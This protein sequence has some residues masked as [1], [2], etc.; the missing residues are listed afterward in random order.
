MKDDKDFAALGAVAD[1]ESIPPVDWPESAGEILA[2]L[3]RLSVRFISAGNEQ[4]SPEAR[5][6]LAGGVISGDLSVRV[7]IDLATGTVAAECTRPRHG[8]VE[9][10]RLQAALAE[11]IN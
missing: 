2:G 1:L 5:A 9:L 7:S 8:P 11:T 6:L 4:L 10:F 3:L